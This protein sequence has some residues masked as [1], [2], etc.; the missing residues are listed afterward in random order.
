M[1]KYVDMTFCE[2][3]DTPLGF[4]VEKFKMGDP[5]QKELYTKHKRPF[6]TK[7][8]TYTEV[9]DETKKPNYARFV[10]EGCVF[11]DFDNKHEADEMHKIILRSGLKCLILTT[12]KGYH[13]LFRVPEF[14]EKEMTGATNWFGYKFDTK[15]SIGDKKVVQIMRVCGMDRE[16]RMSWDMSEPVA[17]STLNIETLDVLP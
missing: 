6:Q 15:A 1:S 12:S 8:L 7:K 16:E 11:I 4:N 13:F 10:P 5:E 3:P 2:L 14:Y 17:P 9:T